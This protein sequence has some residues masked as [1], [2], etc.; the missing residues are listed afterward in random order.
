MKKKFYSVFIVFILLVV[1]STGFLSCNKQEDYWVHKSFQ[2]VVTDLWTED[3]NT[4]FTLKLAGSDSEKKFVINSDSIYVIDFEIG[5]A[6]VVE[7]DYNMKEHNGTD[8]PYPAVM[9]T[10][11]SI[12]DKSD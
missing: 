4:G 2:G 5:D 3:G 9:I 12:M 1:C 11:P 10:D 8:V 7:S 6:V